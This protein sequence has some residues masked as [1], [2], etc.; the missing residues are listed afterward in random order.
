MP[1][2][3]DAHSTTVTTAARAGRDAVADPADAGVGRE[4][5]CS[6][7]THPALQDK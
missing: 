2:N 6:R 3:A 7:F 4:D 1:M 5:M